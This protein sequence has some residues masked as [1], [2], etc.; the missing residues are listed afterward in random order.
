MFSAPVAYRKSLA[1]RRAHQAA[2]EGRIYSVHRVQKNG[3][4]A[5]PSSLDINLS[6]E[7]ANERKADLERMNPGTTYVV[8]S[9]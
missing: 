9:S 8:V 7:R 5:A 2:A 1:A 6:E 3:K 4:L